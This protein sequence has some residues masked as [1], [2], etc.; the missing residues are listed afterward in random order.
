MIV[1]KLATIRP[2]SIRLA[3]VNSSSGV[4]AG[5]ATHVEWFGG[6][7]DSN[8]HVEISLATPGQMGFQRRLARQGL[9]A[10]RQRVRIL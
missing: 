1:T 6:T 7:L 5:Y 9:R 4:R 8:E 2:G 10:N 3:D